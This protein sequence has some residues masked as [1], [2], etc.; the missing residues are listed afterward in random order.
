MAGGKRCDVGG[1]AAADDTAERDVPLAKMADHR[2]LSFA[3]TSVAERKA[4]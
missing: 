2:P 3:K 4:S 1:I